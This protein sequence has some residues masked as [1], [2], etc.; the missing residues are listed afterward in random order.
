M[1]K[2]ME[3]GHL[4]LKNNKIAIDTLE[5]K[6]CLRNQAPIVVKAD[7]NIPVFVL[8]NTAWINTDGVVGFFED[9]YRK[10]NSAGKQD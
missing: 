9:I 5:Q 1:Q 6:G 8:Y 3:L 10:L 2:A 4:V 7:E